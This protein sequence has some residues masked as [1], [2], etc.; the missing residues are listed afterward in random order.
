[1]KT[2]VIAGA[3]GYLGRHLVW[4]YLEEEWHVRALVRD[5]TRAARLDLGRAELVEAQ[6]TKPQ[7]LKGVL[8]GA[9]LVISSLGITRQRDGL[10]YQDVDYQANANL[11]EEALAAGVPQFGYIHVIG[12]KLMKG[13]PLVDAKQAFVDRLQTAPIRS[14]VVAPSGFFS[15]MKDFLEMARA[16]RVW[17][18]GDGYLK[19]N[20]IHG[21]D[22]AAAVFN[23]VEAEQPFF[24]V[25]G[26]DIFTH[27][28]LAQL[29]FAVIGKPQKI[30]HLPD[31]LRRFLIKILPWV[32][33]AHIHGPAK[34]F[35]SAMGSNMVGQPMGTHHLKS[36][37]EELT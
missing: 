5:A 30:A 22:L 33:P 7:T 19:L 12:A 9:D 13:V 2:V 15:D 8:D 16:G 28:E 3:T 18:F 14:T 37:F 36:Y 26:P 17:L 23:A 27:E 10:T 29:A 1:M 31:G 6:A 11:L 4:R 24:E 25:G 21:E 35:L 34:F 20:P 32:T